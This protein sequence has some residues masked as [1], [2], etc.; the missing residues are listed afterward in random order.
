[1]LS[2]YLLN[3]CWTSK[4]VLNEQINIL[5][6]INKYSWISMYWV[7]HYWMNK[8]MISSEWINSLLKSI[9]SEQRHT[10]LETPLS[11]V[12]GNQLSLTQNLTALKLFPA[13]LWLL[14]VCF[15]HLG[16]TEFYKFLNT[17]MMCLDP[18]VNGSAP[19]CR[20]CPEQGHCPLNKDIIPGVRWGADHRE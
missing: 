8:Q 6:W 13:S 15:S 4:Y 20:L 17:L 14:S 10:P 12:N 5:E 2:K 9:T 1:M 3:G 18:S 7:N 16:I 19:G 11:V